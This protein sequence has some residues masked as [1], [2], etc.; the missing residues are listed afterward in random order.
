MIDTK[1]HFVL[2]GLAGWR[3]ADLKNAVLAGGGDTLTLQQSPGSIRPLVD[4]QGSFGGLQAAI[5]VAVDSEN[6][7]Y[8]LDGQACVLKRFDRCRQNFVALPCIGGCGTEPRQF[9]SPHGLAISC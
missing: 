8:I 3:A 9:S 7:V 2:D 5:G 6:G 4:A 1:P